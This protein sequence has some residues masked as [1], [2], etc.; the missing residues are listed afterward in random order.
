MK[1]I[2][3]FFAYVLQM[4]ILFPKLG[5]SFLKTIVFSFAIPKSES[6]SEWLNYIC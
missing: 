6:K 4:I 1:N 3:M 2:L 5:E